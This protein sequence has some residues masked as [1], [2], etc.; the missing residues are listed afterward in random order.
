MTEEDWKLIDGKIKA[1]VAKQ[2]SE[3]LQQAQADWVAAER[4]R[5]HKEFM[6]KRKGRQVWEWGL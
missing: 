5:A 1:E 2:I 6:E 3:I 4:V